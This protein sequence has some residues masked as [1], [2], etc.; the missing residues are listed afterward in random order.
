MA[1][2]RPPHVGT[3]D[4]ARDEFGGLVADVAGREDV[5]ETREFAGVGQ[6]ENASRSGEWDDPVSFGAGTEFAGE[7]PAEGRGFGRRVG[8]DVGDGPDWPERGWPGGGDARRAA[9]TG[10]RAGTAPEESSGR[11]GPRP[12]SLPESLRR[13]RVGVSTQALLGVL[14]VVLVAAAVVG[15]RVWIARS[16]AQP[17]PVEAVSAAPSPGTG[18][19]AGGGRATGRP[20]TGSTPGSASG[21]ASGS[22]SGAAS[23]GGAPGSPATTTAGPVVVHVVGAVKR[24]GVVRL[25]AGARLADAIGRAGGVAAGGDPASVNLA[26]PV[27]DGEQVVVQRRGARP[28]APAAAAGPGAAS[29]RGSGAGSSGASGAKGPAGGPVDLNTADEQ[30]LD[31]LPGI[32]PVMARRILEWRSQ[33]GRFGSVDELAEVAGVG[34]KTLEELRP[35]VRV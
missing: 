20:T 3:R 22:T 18:R 6:R 21:S 4:G 26:R 35:H 29:P 31:A 5:G 7:E 23:G 16:A 14:V 13:A 11:G 28:V 30:A 33:N 24:P 32:G 34:P 2:V 25:P 9:A 12:I 10:V 15:V 1:A 19:S 27:V 8:F 17:Q